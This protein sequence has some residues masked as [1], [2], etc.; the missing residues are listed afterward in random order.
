MLTPVP[1]CDLAGP[2]VPEPG[3]ALTGQLWS[4]RLAGLRSACPAL[5]L[6]EAG[7]LIDVVSSTRVAAPLLRGARAVSAAGRPQAVAWG[8]LQPAGPD[9]EAEFTRG[10]FGH[11]AKPAVLIKV[12]TWC[13][14]AIAAGRF[15]AV[16][17]H[18]GGQRAR[19][20]LDKG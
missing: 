2:R 9:P 19:R 15:N 7:E 14:L 13:W 3:A 4:I 16:T 5:E 17:V 8:R 11:P 18:C 1:R 10:L 6:Y 20:R 12:T